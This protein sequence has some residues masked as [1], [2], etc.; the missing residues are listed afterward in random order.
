MRTTNDSKVSD[1]FVDAKEYEGVLARASELAEGD[2]QVDFVSSL[3]A[4]F[5]KYGMKSFL[6]NKQVDWLRD[7]AQT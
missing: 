5:D 3:I 6:S 7:I 1:F 2:R 4:K